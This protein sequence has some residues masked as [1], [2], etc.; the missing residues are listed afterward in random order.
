MEKW[1]K[2]LLEMGSNQKRKPSGRP[3]SSTYA[4]TIGR[5]LEAFNASPQ[6][7]IHQA[8]YELGV[9]PSS[10]FHALCHEKYNPFK[11]IHVHELLIHTA[12]NDQ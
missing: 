4:V 8:V 12:V 6:T 2:W 9:N 11:T 1:R 7:S 5:I 10:V 3:R